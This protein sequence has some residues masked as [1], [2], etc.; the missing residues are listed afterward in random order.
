LVKDGAGRVLGSVAVVRE[1]TTRFQAEK[2]RRK[3]LAEL[4]AQVAARRREAE[5]M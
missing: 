1:I 5:A 4:E 2:E 3:R